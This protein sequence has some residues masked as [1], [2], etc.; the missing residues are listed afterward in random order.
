MSDGR[1][2]DWDRANE[3]I[4]GYEVD[5]T[6]PR[7]I[8]KAEVMGEDGGMFTVEVDIEERMQRVMFILMPCSPTVH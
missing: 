4:Q 2:K 5:P 8:L 7:K 1:R 3:F 6:R